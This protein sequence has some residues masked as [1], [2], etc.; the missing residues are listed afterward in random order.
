MAKFIK[1][2]GLVQKITD[3][4]EEAEEFLYILSPYYKIAPEHLESFKE[5]DDKGVKIILIYSK[6]DLKIQEVQ[7][8]KQIKNL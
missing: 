3:I 7:K 6:A 1:N 8:L 4:I 5:A 2:K